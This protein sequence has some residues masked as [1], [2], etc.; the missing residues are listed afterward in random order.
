[1]SAN[2]SL[3]RAK[4]AKADEFYTSKETIEA[5]L[6]RYAEQFRGKVVYCNCDDPR[7]SEFVRFFCRNFRAWG[8]KG[9]IATHYEPNERN[10]SY[11]ISADG[12]ETEGP[13][14][15][16]DMRR[17]ELPC[18]GDFRSQACV[19]LLERADVVVTNPPFSLFRE[20]VAQLVA[21]RKSFLVIGN[22]NAAK[23][24]EIFPL[25]QA[26]RIWLGYTSGDMRFK[27]PD[28]YGPRATRYWI[29]EEGQKWR[30]IGNGCWFTNLD[31][32]TR[33]EAIDLRG[34]YYSPEAYPTYVNY[35]AIEVSRVSEIPCDYEGAMG[36]PVTFL[37]KYCPE[38][39]EILGMN[40]SVLAD[41]EL[42]QEIRDNNEVARRLNFYVARPDGKGNAYTRMYDRVVIRNRHPKGR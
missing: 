13:V 40:W 23:Y 33:H 6:P 26:D 30:S 22:Q 37:T 25:L 27:V 28:S 15:P 4:R 1:M 3:N 17:E 38:Q 42:S 21:H 34:N 11:F 5:E 31:T 19:E 18:N 32:R 24:S 8:L 20:Y 29:D 36:V 41:A 12:S 14:T 35:D 39:F 7:E 9:L 16:A 10:F 2:A